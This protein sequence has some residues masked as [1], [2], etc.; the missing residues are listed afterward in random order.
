MKTL[1]RV[2]P[3]MRLRLR[4]RLKPQHKRLLT[5]ASPSEPIFVVPREFGAILSCGGKIYRY[6][7]S[8]E[9]QLALASRFIET[10]TIR[11]RERDSVKVEEGQ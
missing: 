3:T 2:R 11:I 6:E 5:M 4:L 1:S 10:A 9:Q 8:P 7:M